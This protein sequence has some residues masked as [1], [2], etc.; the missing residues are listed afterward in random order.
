MSSVSSIVLVD[1]SCLIALNNIGELSLLTK[2]FDQRIATTV[3]VASEFGLELPSFVR[4]MEMLS[5]ST[6]EQL[7]RSLDDGESSLIALARTLPDVLLILDDAKARQ[8]ATSYGLSVIGT[9]SVILLAK[10][11]RHCARRAVFAKVKIGGLSD[12]IS[13]RANRAERPNRKAK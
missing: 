4:V 10:K 7:R 2:T 12:F 3:Q 11:I 13:I 1:A 6:F 5:S 9:V 8:T